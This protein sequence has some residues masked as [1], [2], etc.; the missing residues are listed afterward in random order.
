M[1]SC[2]MRQSCSLCK[3]YDCGFNCHCDCHKKNQYTITPTFDPLVTPTTASNSTGDE[4]GFTIT[5]GG[6]IV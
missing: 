3:F 1:S 6:D 2:T 4:L 5:R